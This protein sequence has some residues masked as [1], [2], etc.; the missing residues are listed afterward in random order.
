MDARSECLSKEY[1][2]LSDIM[3]FFN[4]GKNKA[5]QIRQMAISKYD[6]FEPVLPQKVKKNAVLK[7]M[8]IK[9]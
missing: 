7:A 5:S 3:F 9:L 6:G 1:W 2:N 8:K 4:C